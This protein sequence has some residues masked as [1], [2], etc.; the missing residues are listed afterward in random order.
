MESRLKLRSDRIWLDIDIPVMNGLD[1]IN[2]H[3]PA[4]QV[5][6]HGLA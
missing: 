4:C 5:L 2:L 1:E 6:R 3:P